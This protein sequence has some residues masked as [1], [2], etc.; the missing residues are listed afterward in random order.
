MTSFTA[1]GPSVLA[2]LFRAQNDTPIAQAQHTLQQA[3]QVVSQLTAANA[4]LRKEASQAQHEV[5]LMKGRRR[6]S[7]QVTHN[8]RES[9]PPD[10]FD[11][12]VTAAA[13]TQSSLR[14]AN[15]RQRD[16]IIIKTTNNDPIHTGQY[17]N[18][19]YVEFAMFAPPTMIAEVSAHIDTLLEPIGGANFRAQL[20]Q[21]FVQSQRLTTGKHHFA[22]H[23]VVKPMSGSGISLEPPANVDADPYWSRVKVF[24][25]M[26]N[27]Y[28]NEFL[29]PLLRSGCTPFCQ[30]VNAGSGKLTSD[31]DI[32]VTNARGGIMKHLAQYITDQVFHADT[33]QQTVIVGGV[34]VEFTT[35]LSDLMDTNVY[36]TNFYDFCR[37]SNQSAPQLMSIDSC[38]LYKSLDNASFQPFAGCQITWSMVRIAVFI[39]AREQAPDAIESDGFDDMVENVFRTVANQD[40]FLKRTGTNGNRVDKIQ[41]IVPGADENTWLSVDDMEKINEMIARDYPNEKSRLAVKDRK[42]VTNYVTGYIRTSKYWKSAYLRAASFIR[43][44]SAPAETQR[45]VLNYCILLV[46][47]CLRDYQIRMLNLWRVYNIRIADAQ[48]AA[49]VAYEADVP[50][51]AARTKAEYE[52]R[53]QTAIAPIL[54]SRKTDIDR[55]QTEYRYEY[56]SLQSMLYMFEE[57]AYYSVGAFVHVVMQMQMG[58]GASE[59]LPPYIYIMSFYDNLG[60]YMQTRKRKYLER[61]E[62]A[63]KRMNTGGSTTVPPRIT[64]LDS[65]REYTSIVSEKLTAYMA[66]QTGKFVDCFHPPTKDSVVLG[67]HVQYNGRQG[68]VITSSPS[69]AVRVRY[70]QS[71]TG[72]PDEEDVS[73]GELRIMNGD[74]N[75]LPPGYVLSPST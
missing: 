50:D 59:T 57:E 31:I 61:M 6:M 72:A 71:Q 73:G 5:A 2:R 65:L 67:D 38:E 62:D 24:V 47:R 35:N 40:K 46:E 3:Q 48:K 55:L 11:R 8:I 60:F 30:F 49:D 43:V 28:V 16:D 69:S 17:D 15:P 1:R 26:R 56:Y 12:I 27:F 23:H 19:N 22:W 51:R 34:T 32:T 41:Q 9:L 42:N 4:S 36:P 45:K 39:K 53:R 18:R 58:V 21:M 74:D 64:S 75:G 52:S 29:I 54:D 33:S 66:S 10:E 14:S 68:I 20:A 37:A 25:N 7:T 13:D 63:V 70:F 44:K